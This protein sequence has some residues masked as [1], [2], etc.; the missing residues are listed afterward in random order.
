MAEQHR[1]L[2]LPDVRGRGDEPG[3]CPKCGMALEARISDGASNPELDD[4]SRR[5]WWALALTIPVLI[6]SMGDMIGD[7][8]LSHL[9]GSV[10]GHGSSLRLQ[11]PFAYGLRGRSSFAP[12]GRWRIDR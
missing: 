9:L 2:L 3:D 7:R 8:H 6:L 10:H 1:A 5:F 12:L 11:P 4:M